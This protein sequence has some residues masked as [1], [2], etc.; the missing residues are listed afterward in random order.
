M[1]NEISLNVILVSCEN[2]EG[3]V[4]NCNH[5]ELPPCGILG[6]IEQKNPN[7]V[8]LSSGGTYQ[9]LKRN[10]FNVID[11]A[12]YT[13][14]PQMKDGLVKSI[15]YKIHSSILAQNFIPE[16]LEFLQNNDLLKIDAVF[17]N[18]KRLDTNGISKIN[19]MERLEEYRSR[20]DLGGPLMCMTSRKGFLNTVLLTDPNDYRSLVDDLNQNDD[21]CSL[22]FRIK[23]LKK[24]NIILDEYNA[25]INKLFSLLD[26]SLRIE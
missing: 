14:A 2:K 20:I 22:S 21:K 7:A 24:S 11:F 12:E 18:F 13:S 1:D 26:E 4:D 15:D 19:T 17:T 25:S 10:R 3:L 5:P 16:D 23:M 9:L 6:V 8:F